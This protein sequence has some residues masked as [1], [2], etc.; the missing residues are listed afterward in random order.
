MTSRLGKRADR[1]NAG[2]ATAQLI[3]GW[4]RQM[5]KPSEAMNVLCSVQAMVC[6]QCRD[7]SKPFDEDQ[8]RA[9]MANMTD[10]V[11]TLILQG[12]EDETGAK[13]N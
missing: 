5:D 2:N 12:Q 8:I 3:Y 6:I 13:P 9:M 1:I 7:R 4:L 11:V 10:N